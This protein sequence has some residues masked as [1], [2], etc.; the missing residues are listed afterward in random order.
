MR[1]P[2]YELNSKFRIKKEICT[3]CVVCRAGVKLLFYQ[4]KVCGV[5]KLT[6]KQFYSAY[7]SLSSFLNNW[8][9]LWEPYHSPH[10][11]QAE[12]DMHVSYLTN[13]IIMFSKHWIEL[14][15]VTTATTLLNATATASLLEISSVNDTVSLNDERHGKSDLQWTVKAKS[16]TTLW[17]RR[18]ERSNSI[19][20][21]DYHF[22]S[23]RST[24]DFHKISVGI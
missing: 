2:K 24:D 10:S 3:F 4:K 5:P 21:I 23:T 9:S 15:S 12:I 16:K 20:G 19:Y 11:W 22:R 7:Q 18:L 1:C 13:S 14:Q 8:S 6:R 17:L